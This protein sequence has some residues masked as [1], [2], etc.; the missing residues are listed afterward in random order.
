MAIS[1][2]LE[3]L[4]GY[5]MNIAGWQPNTD[6]GRI[7]GNDNHERCNESLTNLRPGD[8][9][10]GRGQSILD[11]REQIKLNALAMEKQMHYHS[12][13]QNLN[14]MSKTVY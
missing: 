14:L 11:H 5:I 2:Q 13:T 12:Q 1:F 10:L 3:E 6:Q 8:V 9:Y 7:I 4:V